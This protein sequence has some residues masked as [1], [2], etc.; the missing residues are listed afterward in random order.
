MVE[1]FRKEMY[2]VGRL[3]HPVLSIDKCGA[4]QDLQ[5]STGLLVTGFKVL[6]FL[7]FGSGGGTLR[8]IV[9]IY[10]CGEVGR[11]FK[12]N[13]FIFERCNNQLHQFQDDF[14]QHFESSTKRNHHLKAF[15][16]LKPDELDL[17][18]II[19]V[20]SFR[21][22]TY[23]VDILATWEAPLAVILKSCLTCTMNFMT[24]NA[25]YCLFPNISFMRQQAL[26]TGT[27]APGYSGIQT[28]FDFYKNLRFDIQHQPEMDATFAVDSSLSFLKP[29]SLVDCHTLR[30]L[31][32]Y[33]GRIKPAPPL[34][35]SNS[36]EI[37]Y[38][39]N[40]ITMGGSVYRW[41]LG[42]S[43]Y[44]LA[45]SFLPRVIEV[46]HGMEQAVCGGLLRF[47]VSCHFF[48]CGAKNI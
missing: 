8:C 47:A 19:D 4:F 31:L 36:W 37:S 2:V 41:P 16:N 45:P 40:E 27:F 5:A 28:V 18:S 26:V 3:L 25:V 23:V 29:R 14:A 42:S 43:V 9:P 17:S 24:A 6:H 46:M 39:A 34:I 22:A 48:S 15:N 33:N 13:S 20:W 10:R 21:H 30:V 11:W 44:I 35:K 32:E 1:S 7:D 38:N 12:S